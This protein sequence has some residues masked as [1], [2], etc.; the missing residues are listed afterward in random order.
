MASNLFKMKKKILPTCLQENFKDS[1]GE[2]S[3][4]SYGVFWS[5]R[6]KHRR[7]EAIWQ[8]ASLE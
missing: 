2:L 5:E 3:N 8:S 1:L 7:A 6:V 4:T